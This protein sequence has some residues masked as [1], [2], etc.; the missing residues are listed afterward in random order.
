MPSLITFLA[1][2]VAQQLYHLEHEFSASEEIDEMSISKVKES[3]TK[4]KGPE[5][6]TVDLFTQEW[7][8]SLEGPIGGLKEAP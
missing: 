4:N 7:A 6:L 2:N 1:Q 3:D 5:I 8:K